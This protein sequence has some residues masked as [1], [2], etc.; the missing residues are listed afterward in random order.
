MS[1]MTGNDK[2]DIP[3]LSINFFYSIEYLPIMQL[4][5]YLIVEIEVSSYFLLT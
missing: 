2:N 3:L 5:E 4:K 1:M